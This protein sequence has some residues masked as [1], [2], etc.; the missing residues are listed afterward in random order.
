[1]AFE[2]YAAVQIVLEK[3]MNF[4]QLTFRLVLF[5]GTFLSFSIEC[6]LFFISPIL[7]LAINKLSDFRWKI[8]NFIL[9]LIVC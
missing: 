2:T 8:S 9:E 7:L 5:L 4:F 3:Y 6:C 1:M